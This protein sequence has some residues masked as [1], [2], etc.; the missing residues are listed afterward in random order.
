MTESAL[1]C[2]FEKEAD[3]K[4]RH[5][6]VGMMFAVTVAEVGLQ[7]ASLVRQTDFSFHLYMP[8]LSHLLLAT[9]VIATSWVGWTLSQSPGAR[10]DVS[11]VFEAEF[12]VLLI[13]VTLVICY[14]V[15][16]RS[17]EFDKPEGATKTIWS[18]SAA[19]EAKWILYIFVIYFLW[20]VVTKVMVWRKDR[21]IKQV[22]PWFP[23]YLSRFI[24][25]L[26]CMALALY[27]FTRITDSTRHSQ[28]V[29]ADV[30]LL[31]LVLLFRASKDFVSAM[32]PSKRKVSHSKLRSFAWALGSATVFLVGIYWAENGPPQWLGR[33]IDI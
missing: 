10:H 3:P 11:K 27:A 9:I 7:V 24:P 29:I 20:D 15:L 16:V 32:F 30:A 25:T 26:L 23:N 18:V 21:L 12:L 22:D 1:T 4:L 13:D 8:A 2:K 14:F 28:V 17:V 19:P 33:L 31:A 5:E 6:F